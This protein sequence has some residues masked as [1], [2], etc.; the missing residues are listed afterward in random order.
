MTTTTSGFRGYR[1]SMQ[2]H[3]LERELFEMYMIQARRDRAEKQ[4]CRFGIIKHKFKPMVY[5]K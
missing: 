3:G 5:G 4:S 1:A 2:F